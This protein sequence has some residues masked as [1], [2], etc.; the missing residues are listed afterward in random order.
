MQTLNNSHIPE[1]LNYLAAEPEFN[2]FM[3]G[4]IEKLGMESDQVSCYTADSW[5]PGTTFP[6]F[7]LNYRGNFLVYS[8]AADYDHQTAAAF[9]QTS[10]FRNL[11]GKEELILPLLPHMDKKDV[12]STCLARLDQV[13]ERPSPLSADVRRLTEDDISAVYDLYVQ[14][15]EFSDTYRTLSKEETY[16]NIA[17]NISVIGRTYG[18]MDGGRLVSAAQT[19][20]ENTTSAMIMGVATLPSFRGQGYANATVSRLCKDCLREGMDFLCLFYNNPAAGRIYRSIGFKELGN[21]T[22][23]RNL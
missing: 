10:C 18:I 12:K 13:N 2:L 22:M 23:V 21:Y 3:I 17:Q 15:D 8:H 14:M 19:S 7:I 16:G 5:R 6:Y 1:A 9:L 4:D 20:A 11:S